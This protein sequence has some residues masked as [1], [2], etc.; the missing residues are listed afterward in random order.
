MKQVTDNCTITY[1]IEENEVIIDMI[2]VDY[3][4]R[5]K[6]F[7][8]KAMELFMEEHYGKVITLH[9]Y[10]QEEDISTEMLVEFYKK[11]GFKVVAG[12]SRYGFEM[13]NN[14]Y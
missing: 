12:S 6:G 13:E 7:A 3:N 11:F 14:P 8:K 1:S 5:G 2:E 4:N 10:S 9:A